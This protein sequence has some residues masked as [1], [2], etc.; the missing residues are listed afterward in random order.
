MDGVESW[1]EAADTWAELWEPVSAPARAAIIRAAR[2]E[3]GTRVLDV[4]C[5]P[6][7][8]IADLHDLGAIA[9]GIDP[10][11]RMIELAQRRTPSADIRVGEAERLPWESAFFDVVTA[12]NALQFADDT[13]DALAE[14]ARVVVPGGSIAIANWAEGSRNDLDVIE[15]AVAAA[16]DSEVPTDDDL[17][18][19]GGLADMLGE[20][21]FTVTE[22]DLVETPWLL[23]DRAALVRAI[24]GQDSA[25]V[26]RLADVVTQAASPFR[27]DDGG[28]LLRNAFRYAVARRP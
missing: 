15:R 5:G 18:L 14:F 13:L 10:A 20:A 19:E 23:P 6:G 9:A 28:Y 12:I 1:S 3:P 4:G 7:A 2:I 26:E 22:S 8:F 17:R 11:H 27:T 16:E 24:L 21:G 25:T